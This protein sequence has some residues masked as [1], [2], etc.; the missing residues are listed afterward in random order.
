MLL[1]VF[2]YTANQSSIVIR[3]RLSILDQA[4]QFEFQLSLGTCDF[5]ARCLIS[6]R[7]SGIFQK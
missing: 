4:A 1:K 3:L 2:T 5:V 7:K 6:S